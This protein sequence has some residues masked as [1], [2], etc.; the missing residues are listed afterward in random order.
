MAAEETLVSVAKRMRELDRWVPFRELVARHDADRI[1]FLLSILL[2]AA[3]RFVAP[4]WVACPS[5]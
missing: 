4:W 3:L 2:A 5:C 1:H